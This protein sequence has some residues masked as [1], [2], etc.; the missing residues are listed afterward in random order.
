M[1][2]LFCGNE[3]LSLIRKTEIFNREIFKTE[4]KKDI[5]KELLNI[6]ICNHCG[7]GF[8]DNQFDEETIE[9][10]YKN[11]EYTNPF[12]G[13]SISSWFDRN[14]SVIKIN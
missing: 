7:Y 3:D 6:Y 9:E 4:Y 8:Y 2:C 10:Y 5:H 14:L 13:L 12:D 11:F 1:K